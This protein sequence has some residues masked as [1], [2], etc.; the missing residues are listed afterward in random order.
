MA[1]ENPLASRQTPQFRGSDL[2]HQAKALR[3][4]RRKHTGTRPRRASVQ[5]H[6]R[7]PGEAPSYLLDK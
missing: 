1:P 3:G 2:E 7:A 5:R 6:T 4:S